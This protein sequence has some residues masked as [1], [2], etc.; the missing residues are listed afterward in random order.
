V[1][2]MAALVRLAIGLAAPMA[3]DLITDRHPIFVLRGG[4]NDMGDCPE[5]TTCRI[6]DAFEGIRHH[7]RFGM[8]SEIPMDRLTVK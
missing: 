8:P 7:G 1:V 4:G 6:R 3:H 2:P 5:N